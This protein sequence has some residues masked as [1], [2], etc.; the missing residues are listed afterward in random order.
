[1]RDMPGTGREAATRLSSLGLA[2]SACRACPC[3]APGTAVLGAPNG[4][5]PCDWLF[6]GEAPG[7]LGAAR[8]G[9]PF[10]GDESGRRFERLLAEAGLSRGQVFV[11]NAVLC[12]PCD[13][14]GRNRTPSM[15]EVANCSAF[16]A[17]TIDAVSPRVVVSLGAVALAALGYIEPHDLR[18]RDAAGTPVPWRGRV[19]V[20]LYHPGRQAALHRP[21]E[22]QL[23]DWRALTLA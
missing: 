7:R 4:P 6:V 1:M 5:V 22:T 10:H 17:R 18:L 19:L 14:R 12:L 3:V 16:L 23:A 2:A 15:A 11:T 9:V 8:T 13:G 20:P 21:W